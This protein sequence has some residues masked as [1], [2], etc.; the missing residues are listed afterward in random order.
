LT[1]PFQALWELPHSV[2]IVGLVRRALP[3]RTNLRLTLLLVAL[4]IAALTPGA[5]YAVDCGPIMATDD[6]S[7][8]MSG[9]GWTV[10][11]GRTQVPFDAE[12]LG[13]AHDGLG[14]GRD[15]IV[16][17][18]SSPEIDAA[19]G[20][21]AG[22]S[23]SPVYVGGEL[24]GS[25][26]YGFSYGPSKIGGVT[27]AEDMVDLLGLPSLASTTA[28]ATPRS[29]RLSGALARKVATRTGASVEQAAALRQLQVPLSMSGLG[30]QAMRLLL[31]NFRSRQND[32][33]LPYAGASVDRHAAAVG[34]PL[35]AG[36]NFASVLSYGDVTMAAVAPR[37]T[38]AAARRWPSATRSS[39]A[40][41]SSSVRTPPTRLRSFR[42]RST[43]R[44]SSPRSPSRSESSTR[45]AWPGSASPSAAHRPR[46]R[47]GPSSTSRN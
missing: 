17:E 25:V 1:A 44:S 32:G 26:S 34:D 3:T 4:A 22:M 6:V 11:Q 37:P 47:S 46:C 33:F 20:I 13:V 9:T 2:I 39:S 35:Q 18:V 12:I 27:P 28:R 29:V 40:G 41:R 31:A 42:I 8:G 14:P 24:L 10:A 43:G 38:P 21:W 30:P 7:A 19:G 5:A 15:L 36:D 23:G 16:V 45:T